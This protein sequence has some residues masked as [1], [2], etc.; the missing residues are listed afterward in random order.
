MIFDDDYMG[1][2]RG[3]NTRLTVHEKTVADETCP[4]DECQMNPLM[5]LVFWSWIYDKNVPY[6]KWTWVASSNQPTG[7]EILCL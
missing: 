5:M 6:G 2:M 7:W 3:A 4:C 1:S